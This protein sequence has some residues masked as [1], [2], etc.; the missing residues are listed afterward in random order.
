MSECSWAGG[1]GRDVQKMA[2][3]LPLLSCESSVPVKEN[4]NKKKLNV[5]DYSMHY[6]FILCYLQNQP[7]TCKF[8]RGNQKMFSVGDSPLY[9]IKKAKFLSAL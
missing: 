9:Y 8:Q 3:S 5:D 4:S 6:G 2:P 7:N 1:S